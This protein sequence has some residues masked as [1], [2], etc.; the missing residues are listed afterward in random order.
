M[1][2][3]IYTKQ[4]YKQLKDNLIADGWKRYISHHDVP[5][6]DFEECPYCN[7]PIAFHEGFK[8]TQNPLEYRCFAVCSQC[9]AAFE[10]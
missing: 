6:D 1:T 8:R 10:F 2:D 7:S 9:G 4:L 3:G 5:V